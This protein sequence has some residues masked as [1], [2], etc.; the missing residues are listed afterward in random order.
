MPD[1]QV[2]LWSSFDQNIEKG[3]YAFLEKDFD[4]AL[5]LWRDYVRLTGNSQWKNNC[6]DF[7]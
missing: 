3:E 5:S 2:S 6:N 4:E 7:F 1:E